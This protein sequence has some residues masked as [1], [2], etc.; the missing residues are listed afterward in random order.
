[1]AKTS[2]ITFD[3]AAFKKAAAEI[4]NSKAFRK[5][6]NDRPIDTLTHLGVTLSDNAR[7]ELQNDT[8]SDLAKKIKI[9]G[10]TPAETYV[11]V[12]VSVAVEV[13]VKTRVLPPLETQPAPVKPAE[14]QTVMRSLGS[15]I[16]AINSDKAS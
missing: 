4:S 9:G 11:E 10:G 12:G 8:L 3:K 5:A 15:R 1:M 13:V 6:L 16:K 7:E 14:V 2:D